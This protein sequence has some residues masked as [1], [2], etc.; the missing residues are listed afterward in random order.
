MGMFA[1]IEWIK[2]FK[3]TVNFGFIHGGTLQFDAMQMFSFCISYSIPDNV[4][5]SFKNSSTLSF[6]VAHELTSLIA[7]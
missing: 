3:G 7:E 5:K 2:L 6:E 1:K 4:F